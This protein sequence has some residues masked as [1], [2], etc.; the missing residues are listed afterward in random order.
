MARI[1][2][3]GL[4]RPLQSQLTV[5]LLAG[6][7]QFTHPLNG[8]MSPTTQLV[9]ACCDSLQDLG[10]IR[11]LRTRLPEA[12]IVAVTST[13]HADFVAALEAGADE[14]VS[15]PAGDPRWQRALMSNATGNA[16]ALDASFDAVRVRW[17]LDSLPLPFQNHAL[18]A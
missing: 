18:A 16:D 12:Q 13:P 11:S 10:A 3:H 8:R 15:L 17:V 2:F 6:G 5:A 14:A 9:F 1:A 4:N 7:H